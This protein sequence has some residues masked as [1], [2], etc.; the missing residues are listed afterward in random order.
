MYT[1]Y[2]LLFIAR[3]ETYFLYAIYEFLLNAQVTRN[4]LTMT[5]GNDKDD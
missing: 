2:E 4:F 1:S 3:V 5:Y